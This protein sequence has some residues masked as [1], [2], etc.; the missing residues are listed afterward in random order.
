[1]ILTLYLIFDK[2]ITN[3]LKFS[4]QKDNVKLKVINLLNKQ[5]N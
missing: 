2:I 3:I 4:L 1:M 5:E